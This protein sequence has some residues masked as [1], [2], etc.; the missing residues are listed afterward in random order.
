MVPP[1][2]RP[3]GLATQGDEGHCAFVSPRDRKKF[4]KGSSTAKGSSIFDYTVGTKND[5]ATLAASLAEDRR[6]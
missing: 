5:L 2:S 1:R 6:A 4:T 3:E